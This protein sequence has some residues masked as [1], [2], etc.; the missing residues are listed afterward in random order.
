MYRRSQLQSNPEFKQKKME[1]VYR[2]SH[3]QGANKYTTKNEEHKFSQKKNYLHKDR[4]E[5]KE[6]Y[7]ARRDFG[8]S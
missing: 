1:N 4:E 6:S 8:S 7:P 2:P 5:V 3:M